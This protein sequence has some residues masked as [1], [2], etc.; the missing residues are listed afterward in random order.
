ML[1]F[2]FLV[3]IFGLNISVGFGQSTDSIKLITID[4]ALVESIQILNPEFFYT[5][6]TIVFQRNLE[7]HLFQELGMALDPRR[8]QLENDEQL[9]M[10]RDIFLHIAEEKFWARMV[11]KN[12]QQSS[13]DL[14]MSV[15]RQFYDS[16]PELFNTPVS[17]SFWQVWISDSLKNQKALELISKKLD[18]SLSED[19]GK[20]SEEGLAMNFEENIVMSK[21][22]DLFVYLKDAKIGEIVGPYRIQ[23][24]TV[25]LLLT[26]R[27]GGEP[28]SFEEVKSKCCSMAQDAMKIDYVG[29]LNVLFDNAYKVELSPDLIH[30]KNDMLKK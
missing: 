12:L 17:F 18:K 16:H 4:K 27:S 28:S 21:D 15:C 7:K 1:K 25:Y 14:P 5:D 3:L 13:E 9:L 23:L 8:M 29:R 2:H 24:N 19:L 10:Q 6:D 26:A 20:K 22:N 30:A 11:S